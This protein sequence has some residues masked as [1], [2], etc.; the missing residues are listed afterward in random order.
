MKAEPDGRFT[1]SYP[2]GRVMET[3]PITVES[4]RVEQESESIGSTSPAGRSSRGGAESDATTEW[5]SS[6]CFEEVRGTSTET[7]PRNRPS[8][9]ERRASA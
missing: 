2:D 1:F 3:M 6:A 8:S 4:G 5:P 7:V 9:S